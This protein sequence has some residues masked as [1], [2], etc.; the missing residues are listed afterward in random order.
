M[1][2]SQDLTEARDRREHMLDDI[3]WQ[4]YMSWDKGAT[5]RPFLLRI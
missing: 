2:H 1:E 4:L 3:E 5:F